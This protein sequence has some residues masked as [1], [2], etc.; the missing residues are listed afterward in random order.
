MICKVT[1]HINDAAQ[2]A[3]A[4]YKEGIKFE[5]YQDGAVDVVFEITGY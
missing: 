4:L 5:A 3:A 2:F 1:I